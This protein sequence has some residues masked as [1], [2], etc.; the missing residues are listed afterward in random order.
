M[1]IVDLTSSGSEAEEEEV[2]MVEM[3]PPK[4]DASSMTKDPPPLFRPAD[5]DT[6]DS[7][8]EI[9]SHTSKVNPAPSK[10]SASGVKRK[11]S[12]HPV[13]STSRRPIEPPSKK[14]AI[15]DSVSKEWSCSACTFANEAA[16]LACSICGT[17]RPGLAR[18]PSEADAAASEVLNKPAAKNA[19]AIAEDGWVCHECGTIT[20]HARWSCQI[21]GAIKLSS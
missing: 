15:Q 7:D 20:E 11:A 14:Q 4:V 3:L 18:T 2:D 8:L 12:A 10:A 5:S 9:I 6:D 19:L 13:P 17:V 1:P 21:C 16:F